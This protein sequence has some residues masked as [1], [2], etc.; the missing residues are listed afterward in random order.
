M[1]QNVCN[2]LE[3]LSLVKEGVSIPKG[4]YEL[5]HTPFEESYPTVEGTLALAKDI[6]FEFPDDSKDNELELQLILHGDTKNPSKDIID[7][8]LS[9]DG[10]GYGFRYSKACDLKSC[11]DIAKRLESLL[12]RCKDGDDTL[13]TLKRFGFKD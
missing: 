8:L 1:N 2:I 12:Y 13:S 6:D 11:A 9:I 5:K 4:F 10:E 7:C 3:G